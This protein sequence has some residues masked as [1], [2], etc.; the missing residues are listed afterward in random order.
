M[1]I[2]NL[3]DSSASNETIS[4]GRK[5]CNLI[6]TSIL[7]LNL[8][9]AGYNDDHG[10]RNEIISTRVYS[11]SIIIGLAVITAYASLIE[12]S[13]TYRVGEDFSY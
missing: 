12:Y 7:N 10:R 13:V 11:V 9:E 6:R 2:L 4:F 3:D 1:T 5:I 8:F